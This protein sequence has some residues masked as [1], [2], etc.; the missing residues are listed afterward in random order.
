MLPA[1]PAALLVFALPAGE[2]GSSVQWLTYCAHGN[3]EMVAPGDPARL[4][5]HTNI[6]TLSTGNLRTTAQAA[7]SATCGGV[8][9][10]R[11]CALLTAQ[12][13]DVRT[14]TCEN[15][16][17]GPQSCRG[18]LMAT[19]LR[20]QLDE[21]NA[22]VAAA[23]GHIFSTGCPD[24][25]ADNYDASV[26]T[27]PANNSACAYSCPTLARHFGVPAAKALCYSVVA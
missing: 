5:A 6:F 7:G 21:S 13:A 10:W 15:H 25:A 12:T 14:G 2:A 27:S 8:S 4:E 18:P 20:L 9:M 1:L 24:V 16:R 19:H 11:K 26:T 17:T 22:V 23:R 3:E